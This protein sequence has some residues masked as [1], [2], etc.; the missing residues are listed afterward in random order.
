M[1]LTHSPRPRRGAFTLIELLVVIAII[2]ILMGLLLA[3]VMKAKGKGDQV[4]IRNDIS[5]LAS[6]VD[7]FKSTFK[8]DYLPSRI[9]LKKRMFLVGGGGVLVPN[10]NLNNPLEADSFTFL[11]RLFPHMAGRPAGPFNWVDWDGTGVPADTVIDLEG[12]QCLVFFLS[13]IPT[14]APLGVAIPNRNGNAGSL[15]FAADPTDPSLPPAVTASQPRA[16]PTR[17][18]PFYDGF[19]AARLLLVHGNGNYFYSYADIYGTVPYAYFSSYKAQNGYNRY[20]PT[21]GLAWTDCPSLNVTPYAEFLDPQGSANS[22]SAADR[23]ANPTSFQIICAGADG[24]F[25]RGSLRALSAGD[26]GSPTWSGQTAGG[27]PA[28]WAVSA[29]KPTPQAL[30]FAG[31]DDMTNF[32]PAPLGVA[33]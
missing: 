27:T 6:A 12:D 23:Y 4:R 17:I 11:T 15:G 3:A 26:P 7:T 30:R 16:S 18:G 28:T 8:V 9:R 2:A 22:V 19:Q 14:G 29:G 25:G 5:G 31:N 13:G 33:Q 10:Y 1:K 24:K 20:V 32:H 21:L